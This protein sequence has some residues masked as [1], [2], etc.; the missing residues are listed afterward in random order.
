MISLF[1]GNKVHPSLKSTLRSIKNSF[2]IV[3]CIGSEPFYVFTRQMLLHLD[4][5]KALALT[6]Q[7]SDDLDYYKSEKFER[8]NNS[9]DVNSPK[10]IRKTFLNDDMDTSFAQV[11]QNEI[12]NIL[13]T[14]MYEI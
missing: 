14:E 3:T 12:K 8:D 4:F 6:E 11:N 5:S 7:E 13:E 2:G 9:I 1:A 10:K